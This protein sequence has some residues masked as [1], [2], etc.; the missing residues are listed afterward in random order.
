M[1]LTYKVVSKQPGGI[2]EGTPKRYYPVIAK[3]EVKNLRSLCRD[4][5]SSSS[6]TPSDVMAVLHAFI[7]LIPEA[8][9]G[10]YNVHLDDFGTFSVHAKVEGHEDPKKVTHHHIK[11]MRMKFL[12]S[13]HIKQ[14]IQKFKVRKAK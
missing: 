3:R 8:L 11:E 7:E 12:P 4:I 14:R 9:E 1:T 2:G 13:K 6:L 5:S 10:G